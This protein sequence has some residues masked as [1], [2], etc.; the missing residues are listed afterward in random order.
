MSI[1]KDAGSRKDSKASIITTGKLEKPQ[2]REASGVYRDKVSWAAVFYK[3]I[4]DAVSLAGIKYAFNPREVRWRRILWLVLVAAGFGLMSYQTIE[5]CQFYFSRP[6]SV[7]VT[8]EYHRS[9]PF[10]S[11]A[12]CNVNAFKASLISRTAVGRFLHDYSLSGRKAAERLAQVEASRGIL[13]RFNTSVLYQTFGHRLQDAIMFALWNGERLTMDNFTLKFTD[14]GLCFAFNDKENGLPPLRVSSYGMS[15]G[16]D[17]K[18]NVEQDEY[19]FQPQVRQGVGFQVML[20]DYGT[21]PLIESDGFAVSVGT[22]TFIG[23]E[24]IEHHYKEAPEGDCK[25]KTLKYFD[26]YGH[27]ECLLECATDFYILHCNCSTIVKTEAPQCSIYKYLSCILPTHELFLQ[28]APCRC[29][30]PCFSR[31]YSASVSSLKFPSSLWANVYSGRFSENASHF[32]EN[33]CAMSVYMKDLSIRQVRQHLDYS[34]FSLLSD[35]GGALGL[36][37]GGSVLTFFEVLDLI[38]HSAFV[39]T[40]RLSRRR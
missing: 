35:V 32:R 1:T 17:V 25:N 36:W 34:F 30:R 33:L 3:S 10:P 7:D 29:P 28:T 16:L 24:I 12:I 13:S 11:V 8:V 21:E 40:A 2:E 20:Y 38:G 19:F 39:Y 27:S 15:Y 9:V 6:M 14:W 31:R 22:E 37:L 26:T 23:A 5:R 4:P 18:L